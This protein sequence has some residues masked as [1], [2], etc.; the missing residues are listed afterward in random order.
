MNPLKK[1]NRNKLLSYLIVSL[2]LF[3]F[4]NQS[5]FAQNCLPV[6]FNTLPATVSCNDDVINLN[7]VQTGFAVGQAITPCY[8]VQVT[9][10]AFHSLSINYFSNSTSIG[11]LNVA[12]STIFSGYYTY[13]SP[14][15]NNQ[16]QLCE[17]GLSVLGGNVA[18]TIR[19]CHSN[20]IL[21]SGIWVMDGACQTVNVTPP[22]VMTSG[23]TWSSNSNGLIVI[24]DNGTARFSPA[25]AGP[26]T[27]DITYCWDNG[28]GCQACQTK[29]ITVTSNFNASWTNPGAICSTAGTVDFNTLVTGTP[30]GIWSGNGISPT[31]TFNP[32]GLSGT[33]PITYTVGTG[34]CA[35]TSTLDVVIIQL[36][37]AS[38]SPP[39]GVCQGQSLNLN[40]LVTGT[41]G[42]TWSGQGVS[43]NN[44]NTTGLS[45][46]ITI[47]YSVGTGSCAA[48]STLDIE[49]VDLPNAGWTPPN[50]ICE[51]Q[52]VSLNPLI[53][54]SQG[55]IWSGQGVSGNNFNSSGLSGNIPITYTVGT[56]ACVS[57]STLNIV[58]IE[59]A[60]ASW[61][62]PNGICEGQ[63]VSL[64]PLITGSQGGTWSGQGVT[65][66]NFNASGLNGNISITYTVG[67]GAC[68][69]TSTQNINVTQTAT[70]SWTGPSSICNTSGISDF[71][72]FVNGTGGGTWSGPGI[73]AAGSFNPA[74]Q[75]GNVTINYTVGSGVC[76]A[77]FNAIVNVVNAPQI[78]SFTGETVFCANSPF[79]PLTASGTGNSFQWYNN[80]NLTNPIATGSTFT[81]SNILGNTYW[82][83]QTVGNCVS[84]PL[85]INITI[86]PAPSP[87]NIPA[88]YTFCETTD[89]P[90]LSVIGATGTINW[91][92]DAQLNNLVNTGT[93]YQPIDANVL[94]FWITQTVNGCVSNPAT[95]SLIAQNP[96]TANISPQGP[97]TLCPGESI[98]LR[99]NNQS[100]N[101][102]STGETTQSIIVSSGG[103]ITLTV[104]GECNTATNQV[105][106]FEESVEAI[107]D[108]DKTSGFA[109]LTVN[110]T[111]TSSNSNACVWSI[112]NIPNN[113]INS[114][115]FT[116]DF[117]G[118]Y[119]V[120][121]LCKTTG[122]CEDR[123]TKVI[124]VGESEVELY[125]PKSFTP[126]GDNVND[127]FKVYGIGI[128]T[129]NVQI[130]NRWG[131]LIYQWNGLDGGWDG[132]VAN[133]LVPQDVYAYVI[134]GVDS[135][136]NKIKRLGSVTLLGD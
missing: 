32:S 23:A 88:Q 100:N 60:V 121:L 105:T 118:T 63:I 58:V 108:V 116:F 125:V 28:Q 56:G 44:L 65:A 41:P 67:I 110:F 1:V 90:E 61:N 42:G 96:V 107:F 103:I 119:A 80:A 112:N 34:S 45:G 75:S 48:T 22:G 122:G 86:N 54:G 129:V 30:G 83:T 127:V 133:R 9:T 17:S 131:E 89:L 126:N 57:T 5:A 111:N 4:K 102:W 98:T 59:Q 20:A 130:Y 81:P 7:A 14:S 114:G 101:L 115:T 97:I 36:P 104:S 47:T 135:N 8:Y 132:T 19:D 64:N 43:G 11:I 53:T 85:I 124:S 109:P 6:T 40:P 10:G 136:F 25:A 13:S 3:T 92:S 50:N 12:P 91:Y 123:M 79:T 37:D 95:T 66:N 51:G 84:E 27:W 68:Q 71:N 113:Q 15:A 117:Q 70:A 21:T 16:V 76:A 134:Y 77:S 35:A 55:G 72:S 62:P 120:T 94:N 26:G 29:S 128:S 46:N 33:L 24:N 49:I 87:P 2:G 78:P 82:L 99:S 18:F 52:T 39:N 69:A 93:S 73:N 38:W 31:G 74:N 106:V